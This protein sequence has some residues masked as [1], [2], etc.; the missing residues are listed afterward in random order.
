MNTHIGLW[1]DHKE[2]IIV[3]FA[4]TWKI[5]EKIESNAEKQLRRSGNS[6]LDGPYE[7]LRVPA[8]DRR[9]RKFTNDLNIYYDEVIDYIR[10]AKSILILGPGEAK[11][12]LKNRFEVKNLND[13]IAGIETADSMTDNQI[14]ATVRKHFDN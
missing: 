9:Q 5:I 12:Q 8:E 11:D 6:P 2:A 14:V 10:Q 7:S 3:G 1:I 13:L 4:D